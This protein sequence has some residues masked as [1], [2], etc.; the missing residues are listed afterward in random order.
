V[1]VLSEQEKWIKAKALL[2]EVLDMLDADSE[3]LDRKRLEQIRGFLGY[4]TRTYPCMIPYM[5][6][7]HLT[8]DGWRKNRDG[9]GWQLTMR[10]LRYRAKVAGELGNEEEVADGDAPPLS[11]VR[12][13]VV[14]R[15]ARNAKLSVEQ[16]S[17]P[18]TCPM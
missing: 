8:I 3:R 18:A 9:G 11:F 14:S 5:M 13:Q 12:P 15:H 2:R 1:F 7:L 10:E 6:G 16:H 17:C 4:V